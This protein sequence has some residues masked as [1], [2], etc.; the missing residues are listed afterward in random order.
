MLIA[1]RPSKIG[2]GMAVAP[3]ELDEERVIDVLCQEGF[4]HY[5]N[6]AMLLPKRLSELEVDALLA[7]GEEAPAA[8][9]TA[10]RRQLAGSRAA[11][12][13]LPQIYWELDAEQKQASSG[14]KIDPSALSVAA[15]WALATP[16]REPET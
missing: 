5:N 7:S 15:R 9:S 2:R 11:Q 12:S 3:L 16:A 4:L 14:G 6:A 10:R 1:T 13:A 8:D